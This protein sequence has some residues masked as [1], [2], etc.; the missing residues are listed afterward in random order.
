MGGLAAT[1]FTAFTHSFRS[2]FGSGAEDF[3]GTSTGLIPPV[4]REPSVFRAPS[5]LPWLSRL[6]ELSGLSKTLNVA[7]HTRD[8][9]LPVPP[10]LSGPSSSKRTVVV[11]VRTGF[12]HSLNAYS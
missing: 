3:T 7:K 6:S 9:A 5:E 1:E 12:V 10:T 4:L 11:R 2:S 8:S